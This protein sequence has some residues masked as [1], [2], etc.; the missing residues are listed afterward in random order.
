MEPKMNIFVLN[1]DPRKAAQDHCDR[2]V[3]KMVTEY[4]QL[5]STAHRILNPNDTR[6]FKS[7]HVN[8]PCSIWVRIGDE[9]YQWLY[10]LYDALGQEYKRRYRKDHA[11]HL[12]YR[13]ALKE[14]PEQIP[15]GATRFV[16]AMPDKYKS[17]N[18][19]RSYHNYYVGEKSSFATWKP[20]ASVP[21]WYNELIKEKK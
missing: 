19:V 9:N 10:E 13:L 3:V 17:P 18:P 21:H 16:L 4:A 5:L 2:H 11:S 12:L 20:P 15:K 8:H 6:G 14:I 1:Q 7:T